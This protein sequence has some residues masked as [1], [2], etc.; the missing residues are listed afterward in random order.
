MRGFENV[1]RSGLLIAGL[2][3]LAAGSAVAQNA[4]APAPAPVPQPA[5]ATPTVGKPKLTVGQLEH[6]LGNILDVEKTKFVIE[7]TNTGDGV[8]VINRVQPSCGCTAAKPD[9]TE[10]QPGEKGRIDGEFDPR[11]KEGAQAKTIT[12]FTNDPEQPSTTVTFKSVVEP[13]V[14]I[15]PKVLNFAKVD[16]NQGKTMF[17]TLTCGSPDFKATLATITDDRFQTSVTKTEE[18]EISGRKMYRSTVEVKVAPG[19]RVGRGTATVAV[20]TNEPRAEL[21]NVQLVADITGELEVIPSPATLGNLPAGEPFEAKITL[22]SKNGKAIKVKKVEL[23]RPTN[24]GIEATVQSADSNAQHT[25]TIKGVAPQRAGAM[26]GE[27]AVLTDEPGEEEIK[28][29]FYGFV[30]VAPG[31]GGAQPA[32]QPGQGGQ[33]P[34]V[35]PV[36]VKPAEPA[37]PANTPASPK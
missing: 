23:R 2:L 32:G 12:I 9:K 21:L 29:P 20:R 8:L 15:E 10:Y 1:R 37:S 34:R 28:V 26:Q 5:P 33:P 22:R 7:F 13:L 3:A 35:V 17:V 25:V 18:V 31:A 36:P 4:P 14:K 24:L 16:K 6:D 27:L 19:A 11:N 30:R